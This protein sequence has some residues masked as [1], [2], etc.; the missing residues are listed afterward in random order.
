MGKLVLIDGNSIM[1]RAFYGIMGSK[2]LT[3]KDGKYTNAGR[4]EF[5]PWEASLNSPMQ[6]IGTYRYDGYSSNDGRNINN[7]VTDTKSV[8]SLGYHFSFLKK[9]DHRRSQAKALGTTYQFYIWKS[10]K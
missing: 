1:N 5:R 8:T 7:V 2:A 6:F 10:K 4:P 9:K 3:T